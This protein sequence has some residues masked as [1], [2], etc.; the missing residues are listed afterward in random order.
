MWL[1]TRSQDRDALTAVCRVCGAAVRG[2]IQKV[3]ASDIGRHK[4]ES[5]FYVRVFL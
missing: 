4:I 3:Q 5:Y 2:I 1:P